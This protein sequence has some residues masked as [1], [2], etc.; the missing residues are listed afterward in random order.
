MAAAQGPARTPRGE[1]AGSRK[2]LASSG[3]GIITALHRGALGGIALPGDRGHRPW[4]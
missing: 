2:M 4:G 3:E 1:A